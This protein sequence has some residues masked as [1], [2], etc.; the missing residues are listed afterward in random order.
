[1][2]GKRVVLGIV[3]LMAAGGAVALTLKAIKPPP[4]PK[5]IAIHKVA[6]AQWRPEIGQPLFI[7]VL[8]SDT[9]SGPTSGGGGRCDAIHIVAINPA[10][11]AGTV[12]NFPR[13][14]YVEVAG[15]GTDKINA[16][17]GVGGGAGVMV[18]TLKKL[19]GIPIQYYAITEFTHFQRFINEL[20]GI[21]VDVPYQMRDD[22]YS[23]AHFAKGLLKMDGGQ[24][25][26]FARNRHDTP[27][28]DFSRTDN[29]G[30]LIMSALKKFRAEA[31]DPHRIFD[32]LKVARRHTDISI[33]VPELIKLAL[34]AREI[35]PASLR[36]VTINGSTGTA[37]G[38]SVVFLSPGD[39]YARVRDDAIF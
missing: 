6:G 29:Q 5:T 13:D 38:A 33:P 9:R 15:R 32:Y 27:N 11:K 14:S 18:E 10:A 25:L 31:T 19:T 22:P 12:L 3:I 30:I 24:A 2:K 7:A 26:A 17:C 36:N 35:D 28:G 1:M 20:G 34:V 39:T 23:G 16:A 8:G 4:A 21:E 37:G